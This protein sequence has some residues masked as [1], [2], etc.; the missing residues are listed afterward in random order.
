MYYIFDCRVLQNLRLWWTSFETRMSY[1]RMSS[2]QYLKRT[3][4]VML[5]VRQPSLQGCCEGSLLSLHHLH[6]FLIWAGRLCRR[7]CF[8]L[9]LF[10]LVFGSVRFLLALRSR[11]TA[12]PWRN[13]TDGVQSRFTS[14][15]KL[16]FPPRRL[17]AAP[18]D[19]RVARIKG[20]G[21]AKVW[22][23]LTQWY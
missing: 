10:P 1:L 6:N 20:G 11:L 14:P 21:V 17:T 22:Y 13:W 16:V 19:R 15:V 23:L 8:R 9:C 18:A 5:R 7:L 3:S 12:S 4:F 2:L